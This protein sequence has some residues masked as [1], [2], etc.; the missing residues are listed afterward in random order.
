MRIV[1]AVIC[2]AILLCVGASSASAD[3]R[4]ALVIGND[5]YASLPPDEQLAN[6]VNDAR[7]I[8]DTLQRL[9]FD[10]IRGENL[11]RQAMVDKFEELTERLSVGDTAFFFFSGHGVAINGGNYILPADVPNIASGQEM[12]LAHGA[13]G[14]ADI[15]AE[16]QARGVRVAVVVLDACRNNPFRRPGFKSVGAERGLVRSEPAQGVF[17]LYSAGIGQTALDRLGSADTNPNSVF[18]RVLIPALAKPGLSLSDLAL[19]VRE[20]V[21][22]LAATVRH[23][24]FPAYYDQT[25]GGRIYLAGLPKQGE[26]GLA[27]AQPSAGSSYAVS[28]CD[29]LASHPLDPE[30]PAGVAGVE[31]D[32]IRPAEAVPACRAAVAR[33]PNDQ[34]MA[35]QLGRTLQ[36]VGSVDAVAEAAR[37]Y[38]QAAEAGNLLG[39]NNLGLMYAN[40]TGVAK[41]AAEAVRWFRK[42]VEADNA[43]GMSNLGFMYANGTG[44]AKDAAEAARWYRKAAEA[45]N[46][47]GMHN[48]AIMYANGTG[49]AKD[50]A[51]A[52]RWYRK[53]ANAGDA[54]GMTNLGTMYFKGTGVAKNEAEAVRWFRKAAENGNA[55]GMVSLGVMFFYGSGVVAKD[56]AEAARWFRKAADGGNARAMYFLGF[57][58]DE[59]R[60][61]AKDEAEAARWYRKA[62]EAGDAYGMNA[63]GFMYDQGVVVA[64]DAV[65]AARW[66]RKAADAGNANGMYNLG[67]MYANGTGVAKDEAEAV[68]WYRKAADGGNANALYNLGARYENGSGVAKDK[69]EAVRLYRKAAES[70]SE[71]ASAALKRLKQ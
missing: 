23:E 42:A 49:V 64:K 69:A 15:V 7:A 8:G 30:R 59:G 57:S 43:Q 9:G 13:L 26:T 4:V 17:T 58:Y 44:V 2:A 71:K 12:R 29:R 45:G 18:T 6:A 25:V 36:K 39:M 11:G 40:G 50:E 28:E 35:V 51:E 41:D 62:A 19:D 65:E 56:H 53:A 33:R 21:R 22:R 27:I 61:V 20:E 16:L 70:G 5:R 38:R 1:V 37:L 63:L 67:V 47:D 54:D 66:Y 60:G 34:R 31:F 48:L 32:A 3:K 24:Q 55:E 68:R 14:E 52:V 46:A 10:V